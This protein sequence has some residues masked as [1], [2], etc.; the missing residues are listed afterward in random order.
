MRTLTAGL[1]VAFLF[2]L[3]LLVAAGMNGITATHFAINLTLALGIA[4]TLSTIFLIIR[5]DL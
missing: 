1:Y 4:A 2:R 3:A 5:G